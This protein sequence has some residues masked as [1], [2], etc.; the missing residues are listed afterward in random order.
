MSASTERK[1]AAIMLADIAGFSSLMERDESGTFDRVRVLREQLIAPRVA[2]HG[3]RIIKTTGDGFLAEFPSAT[4]A[5]RC[6]VEIQRANHAQETSRPEAERIHMRIGLNVGDIIIDGDD[7]AGDG[8]IIAARLEPLAPLDGICVS[9]T[10]REHIRQDLGV[11]YLDLGDQQVKNISRPIR[12][13][14]VN[15][16]VKEGLKVEPL[17]SDKQDK[18]TVAFR[19]AMP[20]L[21]ILAVL[22]VGLLAWRGGYISSSTSA[23]APYSAQ[24]LRMSF[25]VLP[26][27]APDGDKAAAAFAD[28]V[29]EAFIDRQTNSPWAR[30]VS[31]GSV[32]D[33]LKKHASATD[34]GR[35]L[36]VHFL[37][38]GNV[39]RAGD[40]YNVTASIIDA[41]TDRVL[42]TKEFSWSSGKAVN[43]YSS[44]INRTVGLLAGMGFQ[45][46]LARTRLKK[47]EDLDVRDLA[48]L[49]N[50]AWNNDKASYEIAM[51]LL[52]RALSLAPDDRLALRLLVNMNLC[53]CRNSWS[54]NPQEQEK[55]GADAI[56]RYL[57]KYPNDRFMT[58]QKMGLYELHGRFEDA[59]VLV[60]RLLEKNPEDP[61]LLSAKAF[62]RFKLG[63]STEALVLLEDAM[64]QDS[65]TWRRALAAAVHYSLGH[66]VEASDLAR[67]AAAEM[68]KAELA[69]PASGAVRLIQV[70]AEA[71]L[72]HMQQAKA[73]LAD[74]AAA[75]PDARTISAIKKWMGPHAVLAGYE[76]FYEGLRKAGVPE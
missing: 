8:V 4:S 14:Q 54:I 9:G 35:V 65:S 52:Q 49:A 34:L 21:A 44:Q 16:T 62:E 67:K 22:A 31:R 30:V 47:S 76:P 48:Y 11:E 51:P 15:L 29:T 59:L 66:Y 43:G 25:A 27:S 68:G 46:E 1:L 26:I 61:E 10:V 60:D 6:G 20:G 75:V 72:G 23:V 64:R 13:Y 41:E 53:E 56:E 57:A 37:L 28:A 40:A 74:F 33:A 69:H 3:G 36:N 42:G 2:E 5:L 71:N 63:R 73:A 12:A 19:A 39:T 18:K 32:Q 58:L 50:D 70:A 7:I 45:I 24:D 38:R 55:I 17:K